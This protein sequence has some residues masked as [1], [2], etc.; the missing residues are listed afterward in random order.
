MSSSKPAW[1]R[2]IGRVSVYQREERYWIYYRQGKQFRYPEPIVR[3]HW[4]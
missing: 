3:K 2:R 4:P 1:R